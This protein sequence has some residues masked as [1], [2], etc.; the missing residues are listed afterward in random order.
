MDSM[1]IK[2]MSDT[3]GGEVLDV[4]VDQLLAEDGLPDACLEAL[5][6][7]GVLVF[8]DLDL[9]DQTQ[10]AFCKRLGDV[11]AVP[12]H[13]I[14]EITV[15]S[16]DP[17]NPLADYF[18]GAFEWHLDGTT[19]TIPCKAAVLTAHAVADT[20][21]ETEFVSTYAAYDMLSDEEKDRFASLRVVHTF[22]ASQRRTHPDPTPE[23]LA[24]WRTRPPKE[25]P[26]VWLHRSGRK[27]L[28]MGATADHVAGMDLEEGRALL[29]DL[30]ERATSPERVFSHQWAVGD[31]VIWDN[32]GVLHRGRPYDTSTPRELHRSTIVGDEVIGG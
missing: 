29:D 28:V 14:P 32:R 17:A 23:Q 19:D 22:E 2:K 11:V 1:T 13:P 6:E 10:V 12:S 31:T 25:H 20:G 27:S 5:D 21:G 8:R 18:K 4:D 24:D 9:D 26:L 15:I 3:V 30:L 7:N 16:L